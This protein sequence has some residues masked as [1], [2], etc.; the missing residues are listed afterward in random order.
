MLLH[1]DA[2]RRL[3]DAL[4]DRESP[5]ARLWLRRLTFAIVIGSTVGLW[6]SGRRWSRPACLPASKFFR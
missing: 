3:R 1:A 2:L 6:V 4:A 5:N